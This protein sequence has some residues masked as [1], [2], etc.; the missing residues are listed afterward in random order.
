MC[1]L[2]GIDELSGNLPELS[3]EEVQQMQSNV[4]EVPN[5]KINK[6]KDFT[7]VSNLKNIKDDQI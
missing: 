2:L 4:D 3:S 6:A 7:N 1:I 5:T